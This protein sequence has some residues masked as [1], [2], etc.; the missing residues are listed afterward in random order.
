MTSIQI[1]Q[2]SVE[3]L[4]REFFQKSVGTWNSQRRYYIL[5]PDVATR[6]VVSIITVEFLEQGCAKLIKLAQDQS[7]EDKTVLSFGSYVTWESSYT[8]TSRKP[9]KGS[10]IF[11]GFGNILYRDRGLTTKAPLQ[12]IYSLPTPQTLC[13]R[14][15][16]SG[17]VFEEEIK[18]IGENY[19]TRQTIISRSGQ[20]IMIGQYLEKRIN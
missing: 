5:K 8:G 1:P 12:A 16:Y 15:E 14:T 9:F 10:T 20:E 11:G 19:R 3:T 4:A 2:L 13:L 6:E 18:L 17:S 7:L